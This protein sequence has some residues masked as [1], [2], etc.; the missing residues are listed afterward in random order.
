MSEYLDMHG[1]R[2]VE[3]LS[4]QYWVAPDNC[5]GRGQYQP[6]DHCQAAALL[7]EAAELEQDKRHLLGVCNEHSDEAKRLRARIAELERERDNL[8]WVLREVA[9]GHW[10]DPPEAREIA[11]AGL[12]EN[13]DE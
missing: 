6:C 10:F 4:C 1:R 9:E 13:D 7:R 2:I 11:R 8:L 5:T 12:E 3:R